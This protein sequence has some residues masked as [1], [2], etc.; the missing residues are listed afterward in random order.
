MLVREGIAPENADKDV[1]FRTTY[2]FRVFDYCGLKK[3]VNFAATQSKVPLYTVMNDAMYRFTMTGKADTLFTDIHFESGT[4]KSYELDPLGSSPVY[5]PT[6]RRY[7]FGN[8]T[9][10]A[11]DAGE[12][13]SS[14]GGAES[15][16]GQS[17]TKDPNAALKETLDK[18]NVTLNKFA[19]NEEAKKLALKK[20]E[21]TLKA[22]FGPAPNIQCEDGKDPV[23]RGFQILGPEGWRTFN[24]DER[25]IMAMST[26]AKPLT[27]VLRELSN[28]VLA[29]KE[30]EQGRSLA[31]LRE[32]YR[33]LEADQA[34][35]PGFD[36]KQVDRTG[37][38]QGVETKGD[39]DATKTGCSSIALRVKAIKDALGKEQP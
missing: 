3:R 7:V 12:P 24:Q 18:L 39:G 15:G 20:V 34:L 37:C 32:Q 10:I 21:E 8:P 30:S 26:S 11:R 2:Y 29:A 33:V 13:K 31:L 6:T 36:L 14:E 22:T 28:R 17:E 9:D 4:L 23:R 19:D 16:V 1:A 27:S 38:P 25:L 35:S 5:D